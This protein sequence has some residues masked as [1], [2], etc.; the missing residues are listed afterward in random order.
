MVVLVIFLIVVLA[1]L[2]F[3]QQ[4]SFGARANGDRLEK[5]RISPHY[6]QLRFE[7]LNPTPALTEGASYGNILWE[8]AFRRHKRGRPNDKLPSCKMNLHTLSPKEDLL[9]WMGHSSYY[10]QIAGK[11]VLVDPVLS[12]AAS[13]LSFTTKAFPGT[14]VYELADIPEL[15]YLLI[16]HDHWDHMDHATLVALEKRTTQVITGLGNGAHLEHWGYPTHKIVE[17]DWNEKKQL[18]QEL[19]IV[20]LPARHFSG[21][22]LKR[23][24]H[25][26]VSFALISPQSKV[27]IG[28][29]SGYDTHFDQIG[30]QYGAF[31]LAILE[32]GQYDKNWKYIHMH[33]AEVL[34]AAK[35]L[36]A[37]QL[38]PVHWGKFQL[39]NHAWDESVNTLLA[40]HTPQHPP[41]TTPMI[42]AVIS[43][44]APAVTERWWEGI[45]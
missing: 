27:F 25:L 13:P 21:R 32:C 29:D 41:I 45:V 26:W 43:I 2:F 9:V 33:P 44:H 20:A 16:T 10:L 12:G 38:L 22:G 15:D 30:A 17:L 31:D 35:E 24:G 8:F 7:N 36:K 28:G 19:D 14:D 6:Q 3:F 34:Q 42:G 5:M 11:R 37:K 18:G 40:L 39:G 1:V 23:N 4:A